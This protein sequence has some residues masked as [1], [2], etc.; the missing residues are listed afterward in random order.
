MKKRGLSGA[1]L[2]LTYPGRHRDERER[3][4][5]TISQICL[6]EERG[7]ALTLAPLVGFRALRCWLATGG[8][9][10]EAE[11]FHKVGGSLAGLGGILR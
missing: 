6:P 3:L 4:G 7:R 5:A 11:E 2:S 8:T 9:I 1:R 10:S